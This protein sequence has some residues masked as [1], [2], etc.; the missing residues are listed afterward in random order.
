MH[1]EAQA[2]IEARPYVRAGSFSVLATVVAFSPMFYDESGSGNLGRMDQSRIWTK[3]SG[4]S[5]IF[6]YDPRP[7][8]MIVVIIG[9]MWI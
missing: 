3:F 4:R 5:H 6:A 1:F 7:P 9:G 8:I 2:E